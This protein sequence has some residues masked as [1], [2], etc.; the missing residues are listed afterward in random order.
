MTDDLPRVLCVDDEPRVLDGLNRLIGDSYTLTTATSGAEGLEILSREPEFDAVVSDMRMPGMD[1]ARFLAR[2][3][4]L[5]P[6]SPRVLLTGQ[7]E[8]QSAIQ[9]I[10]EGGIFRFLCKPCGEAQLRATLAAA[11][12]QHRLET[13]EQALL[14]DTVG[15]ILK[16]LTELLQV[17]M[18]EAFGRSSAARRIVAHLVQEMGLE[19]GWIYEAAAALAPLG[20]VS[21]PPDTLARAL[22]GKALAAADDEAVR[23]HP[24]V[25]A[26]LLAQV[27]RFETVAEIVRRQEDLIRMDPCRDPVEIGVVLLQVAR[28]ADQR[29]GLGHPLHTIVS[30]LAARFPFPTARRAIAALGTWVPPETAGEVRN[31]SASALRAGMIAEDGVRTRA[32][33]L[34][35]PPGRELD[36]VV[37]ERLRRFAETAG[38]TEPIR[39]RVG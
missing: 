36:Q 24:A 22:S 34:L 16:L 31:L 8:L 39:V 15:Q 17:T 5:H 33:M 35:V 12:R 29:L 32:G 18:P 3:A 13:A 20:L 26:R 19:D 9:A 37:L 11:V 4:V 1:G 38:L 10:N 6:R 14:R 30:E 2:V 28:E 25:G 23:A 7:A 21:V 27:A